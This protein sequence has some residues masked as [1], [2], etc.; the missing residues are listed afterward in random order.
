[1]L[2]RFAQGS[3]VLVVVLAGGRAHGGDPPRASASGAPR[4]KAAV[5]SSDP[6]QALFDDGVADMEAGR[7]EKACPSIEASQRMDPRPGTLFTL[8]ECEAL[9]G[10]TATSM[11]YY[12]EYLTLFRNFTSAKKLE[13]KDRGKTSEDQLRKLEL[14][15]PKLTIVLRDGSGPDVIVRRDGEVV[16]SLSLGTALPVDPGEHVITAQSPGGPEIEQRVSLSPGEAKTV[17]LA[18]RRDAAPAS[19]VTAAPS[20]LAS[21][22]GSGRPFAEIQQPWRIS[23][24]TFGA[25]GLTGLVVGAVTGILAAQLRPTVERNCPSKNG[26]ESC[27]PLGFAAYNRLQTLGAV[28]TA[29]LV[30]GGVGMGIGVVLL[31]A[32]PTV[33]TSSPT[34][35][36]PRTSAF[37]GPGVAI[38]VGG[39]F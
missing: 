26:D 2:R 14:L 7:F 31:L 18:V 1:M 9:R 30:A 36:Q 38:H 19:T 32:T 28:S 4:T 33:P 10:R 17:R 15:V 27:S 16:A 35:G 20:A 22:L 34:V 23:T 5:A 11:R 21:A 39:S 37:V 13:Q 3:F 25:V 12:A 24:W 8:A 29:S 6:A